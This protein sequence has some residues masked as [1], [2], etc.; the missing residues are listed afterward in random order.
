MTTEWSLIYPPTGRPS[1]LCLTSVL[2]AK[3]R[4]QAKKGH[5]HNELFSG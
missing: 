1:P 2:G 5:A 3:V 4:R